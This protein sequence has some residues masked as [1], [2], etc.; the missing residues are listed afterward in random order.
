MCF[1]IYGGN[2]SGDCPLEREDQKSFVEYVRKLYPQTHGALIVHVS[3]EGKR[4][5]RQ[6]AFL[7]G[8]GQTKGASDIIIPG[9]P[10]F[11]CEIKRNDKSKSRLSMDQYNY[12]KAASDAGCFACVCYGFDEAI[13]AFSEWMRVNKLGG[14]DYK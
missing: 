7:K 3:N 12:L 1:K 5:Y 10:A 13:K 6:A 4:N 11:V 9:N 8:Q 14:F 2:Y